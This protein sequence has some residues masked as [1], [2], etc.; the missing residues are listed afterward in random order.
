MVFGEQCQRR[1]QCRMLRARHLTI[2][3]RARAC[4][5]TH[6]YMCI[7]WCCTSVNKKKRTKK[8]FTNANKICCTRT[9]CVA[10]GRAGAIA[11][12]LLSACV[13]KKII[14]MTRLHLLRKYFY[15]KETKHGKRR[16]TTEKNRTEQNRTEQK[17][18]I[19]I[20]NDEKRMERRQK[21]RRASDVDADVDAMATNIYT[22]KRKKFN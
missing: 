2:C 5:L 10:G 6:A 20:E 18:E 16:K 15:L 1:R 7:I 8:V 9:A 19:Y 22:E 21:K 4:S 3:V 11:C 13:H 12:S 17:G 14:K